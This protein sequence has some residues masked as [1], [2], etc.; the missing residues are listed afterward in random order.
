MAQQTRSSE[1]KSLP[2]LINELWELI[3]AYF[4]QESV[5]PLKDVVRFVAFGVAGAILISVGLVLVGIG[6][7]RALEFEKVIRRHLSGNLTWLPYVGVVIASVAVAVISVTRI[8]K[9]PS[10]E[11][12]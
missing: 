11:E 6:G 12:P 8:F 7:L 10:R 3:V 1:A 4:K 2:T 5:D 9:V